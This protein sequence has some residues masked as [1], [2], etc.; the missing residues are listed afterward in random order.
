MALLKI[1]KLDEIQEKKILS[2][3]TNYGMIAI[4]KLNG[5]VIAFQDECTHDGSPFDNAEL[6]Q[7]RNEIIC[8]RHGARF[9]VYSGEATKPPAYVPIQIYKVKIENEDVFIEID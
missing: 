9:N 8:P 7:I 4:T 1:A 5:N 3:L 6:D 2:K